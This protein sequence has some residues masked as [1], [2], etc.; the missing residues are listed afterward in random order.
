MEGA[1]DALWTGKATSIRAAA[2]LF[3]LNRATLANRL[4]GRPT[5]TQARQLQYVLSE[6]QEGDLLKWIL[7]MEAIGHAIS[8]VQIRE[9]AGL[10]S[11][12][13]GGP[14][15]VGT[16][17]VQRFIRRH[18]LVHVKVGR[19]ID[20]LRVEAATPEGLQGWFELFNRIKSAGNIKAENMWNMDETGLVLGLYKNQMVIRTS[21]T[22]YS[23]VKCP[24]DREWVSVV[25]CVSATGHQCRPVYI[26][27]GQ[28]L[29]TS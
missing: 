24:Q 7:E 26:F 9:M 2:T 27:K 10:F 17:W 23:Y 13:S 20:H 16:K 5:R 6:A 14:P 8:H 21:N 22:K 15:S 4:N 19:V 1:I 25:E 11:A 28:S 29:Q 3:G 18:P 12:Y